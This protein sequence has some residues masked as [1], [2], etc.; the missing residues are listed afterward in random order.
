MYTIEWIPEN[1]IFL[2]NWKSL[3]VK[4][5][6]SASLSECLLVLAIGPGLEEM[7]LV[8]GEMFS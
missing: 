5:Q 8:W 6:F 4:Q 7:V 3:T 2:K 1:I